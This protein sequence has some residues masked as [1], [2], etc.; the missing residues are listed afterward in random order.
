M[1]TIIFYEKPGCKN[2]AKQKVLLKAAGHTVD[3]RNLLTTAWTKETL[4]PFFGDLPVP[5]WFNAT[6]PKIKSKE[7]IPTQLEPDTA[8]ELM[9]ADPLLIRRPLLQVG[10]R[11]EVGFDKQKIADWIGLEALET[12]PQVVYDRLLQEDLETCSKL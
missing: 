3:D 4:R 2:N 6:A 12:A 8:L 10:D 1:A 5:Q 9:I 7:I 11:Q